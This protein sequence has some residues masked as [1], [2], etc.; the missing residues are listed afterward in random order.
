MTD[1]RLYV[2]VRSDLASLTPGKCAAQVAH[3]ASQAA[4]NAYRLDEA[5]STDLVIG[6]R[7][8]EYSPRTEQNPDSKHPAHVFMGFGTTIVLDGIN[9]DTMD[10]LFYDSFNRAG[11]SKDACGIVVDPS[12]PISDGLVTHT[13]EAMT[14]V[15]AFLDNNVKYPFLS[16]FDLYQGNRV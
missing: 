10:K 2:W 6:Y 14:C 8:W 4:Y 9:P 16:K 12:Y 5:E 13:I 1:Y 3:A 15:W 7:T 11:I